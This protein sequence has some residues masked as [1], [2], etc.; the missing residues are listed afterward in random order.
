MLSITDIFTSSK[1]PYDRIQHALIT[2]AIV[3]VATALGA[4][5]GPLAHSI[6]LMVAGPATGTLIGMGWGVGMFYGREHAQARQK[7]K[8]RGVLGAAADWSVVW[9]GTWSR[10]GLGDF[11]V[12]IPAAVITGLCCLY[13]LGAS[14]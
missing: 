2:V 4:L 10:D 11:L 5:T 3:L 1:H 8:D 7:Q 14:H 6:G 13:L 9:P 12:S